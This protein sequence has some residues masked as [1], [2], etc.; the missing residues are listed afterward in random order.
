[1]KETGIKRTEDGIFCEQ[2][3]ADLTAEGSTRFSAHLDGTTF[4]TNE[5]TCNRCGA[6]I[7]QTYDRDAED[8]AEWAT[9]EKA[10]T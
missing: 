4:Y 8:A 1:M 9:D 10:E 5:F 3:G 7:S 6:V 2:C